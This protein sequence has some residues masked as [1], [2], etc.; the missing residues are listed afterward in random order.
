MRLRPTCR[1]GFGRGYGMNFGVNDVNS[2]EL[3][4]NQKSMLQNQIN[5]IDKQLKTYNT[6]SD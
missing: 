4:Q 2:K 5:L 1:R 6:Y 3:L